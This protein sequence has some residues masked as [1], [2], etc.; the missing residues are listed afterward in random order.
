M[1]KFENL[2]WA[3][4]DVA[5][6]EGVAMAAGDLSAMRSAAHKL[7][8]GITELDVQEKHWA[9]DA[10]RCVRDVYVEMEIASPKETERYRNALDQAKKL[11]LWPPEHPASWSGWVKDYKEGR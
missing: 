3:I 6:S 7:R 4:E 11:G 1:P 9:L 5:E 8:H 2:A 10:I